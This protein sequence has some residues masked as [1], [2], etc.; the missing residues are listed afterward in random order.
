M[1][2]DFRRTAARN[3]RR[4]GLS[5]QE[6]MAIT[7]HKTSSVFRR[8]A[9]VAEGDLRDAVVRSQTFLLV[10]VPKVCQP[11]TQ[12]AQEEQPATS[13]PVAASVE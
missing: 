6:A 8:Y 5:E 3:F 12:S 13:Q 9:I 7:G 2:H 4:A 10:S 1:L 11:A